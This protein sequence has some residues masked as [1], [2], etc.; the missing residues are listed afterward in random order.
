MDVHINIEVAHI[1]R[2][3]MLQIC[4]T[5]SIDVVRL[6]HTLGNLKEATGGC[7]VEGGPAFIVSSV[8]LASTLHQE[9]HHLQIL[10]N[11]GLGKTRSKTRTDTQYEVKYQAPWPS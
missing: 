2:A 6:G 9:L 5:P 8:H 3:A 1:H 7:S 4:T 10:V 11:A